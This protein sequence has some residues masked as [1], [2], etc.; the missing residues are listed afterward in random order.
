MNKYKRSWLEVIDKH[1][2]RLRDEISILEKERK[3]V[4]EL[5]E[6]MEVDGDYYNLHHLEYTSIA[7]DLLVIYKRKGRHEINKIIKL[8]EKF[9]C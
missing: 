3:I 7:N 6:K 5:D 2:Q 1:R 9:V 4:Y 8:N